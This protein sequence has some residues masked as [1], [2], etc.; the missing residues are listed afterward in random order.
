LEINQTNL[1]EFEEFLKRGRLIPLR[2]TKFYAYWVDRFLKYYRHRPYQPLYQIIV[3]YL[4][5]ME[6]DFHFADWQMKQTA[7]AIL[8][9]AEKY[10]KSEKKITTSMSDSSE[11][12]R[13]SRSSDNRWEGCEELSELSCSL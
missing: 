7:D 10:I 6:T 9:Y 1:L 4:K 5:T 2:R 8:L 11:I 3:S 13:R 12:L